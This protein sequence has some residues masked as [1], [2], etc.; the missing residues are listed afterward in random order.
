M[1]VPT[2]RLRPTVIPSSKAATTKLRT[3]I[4]VKRTDVDIHGYG[5][6]ELH[7]AYKDVGV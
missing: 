3:P 4:H 7:L 6:V 2:S 5:L 1:L